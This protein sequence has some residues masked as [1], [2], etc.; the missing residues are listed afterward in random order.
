[1]PQIDVGMDMGMDK[2][3]DVGLHRLGPPTRG[4][5]PAS[6]SARRWRGP[7][8]SPGSKVNELCTGQGG[9]GRAWAGEVSVG[10]PHT[11]FTGWLLSAARP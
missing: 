6:P 10:S 5:P 4:K 1:M 11:H 9:E 2:G 8:S 3:M 7:V